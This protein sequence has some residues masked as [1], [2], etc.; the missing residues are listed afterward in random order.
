MQ[1]NNHLQQHSQRAALHNEIHARPPEAMSAPLAISHVVMVC[2]AAQRKPAVP[3]WL[4][5]CATTICPSR[6]WSPLTSAWR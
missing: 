6:T 2:D 1:L 3:M 4:P 5:C